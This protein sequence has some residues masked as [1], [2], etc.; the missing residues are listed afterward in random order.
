MDHV[1]EILWCAQLQPSLG[2]GT[3][4]QQLPRLTN[5]LRIKPW[6]LHDMKCFPPQWTVVL[7]IHRWIPFTRVSYVKRWY[8]FVAVNLDMLLKKTDELLVML[9]DATTRAVSLFP[10]SHHSNSDAL[11]YQFFLWYDICDTI[12][13]RPSRHVMGLADDLA[14]LGH[15][16]ICKDHPDLNLRSFHGVR[17]FASWL[18]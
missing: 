8:V 15:R 6:C 18:M 9:L 5:R 10:R 1:N 13:L 3:G 11:L 17:Y 7:G 16:S 14:P 12:Q 2:N 4:G